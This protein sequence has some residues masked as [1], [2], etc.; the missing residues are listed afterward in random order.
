[1]RP[2]VLLVVLAAATATGASARMVRVAVSEPRAYGY[3]LGDVVRRDVELSVEAGARLEAAS[4]PRP[5]P[6]NYW[7]E[8]RSVDLDEQSVAGGTRVHISLEYQAFY[9][10]L[11][12]RRLTIPGFTLKVA[13]QG[14]TEQAQIPAWSFV[15]SPLRELFPGKEDEASAVAMRPDVPPP[16]LATGRER[17]ALLAASIASLASLML[18]A[19]FLAWW[20][21][22][23][24]PGRPFT[25]AARYLQANT[26][27]LTGEGGY[28]AA[29]IKLHRAFDLAAGRRVLPDDLEAFL[30][31]HPEFAPYAADIE[32]LFACSRAAF[33][34]NDNARA[35]AAMPFKAIADLGLRLGAA[36]R[37]AG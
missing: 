32:R 3:F 26:T 30:K 12:P 8:L 2:L 14:G 37:R 31:E 36:E 21:F 11:D 5:G 15:V 7:L 16:L 29:L 23:R 1:M 34:G 17:T 19:R 22:R 18:L 35:R 25:E 24:R 4:L 28:R 6:I 9:A 27:Q 10:A 33:F 20:P 13:G